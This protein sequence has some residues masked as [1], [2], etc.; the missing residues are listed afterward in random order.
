MKSMTIPDQCIK[1]VRKVCTEED[2]E[3]FE[4]MV[5]AVQYAMEIGLNSYQYDVVKCKHEDK[6]LWYILLR[7]CV[8]V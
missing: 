8:H 1:T 2:T 3:Y 7:R 5:A 6:Y 4:S